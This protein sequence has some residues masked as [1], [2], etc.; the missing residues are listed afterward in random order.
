M[1]RR[2]FSSSQLPHLEQSIRKVVSIALRKQES[3]F[4]HFYPCMHACMFWTYSYVLSSFSQRRSTLRCHIQVTSLYHTPYIIR[5][6]FYLLY[7]FLNSLLTYLIFY[8]ICTVFSFRRIFF[9]RRSREEI[10]AISVQGYSLRDVFKVHFSPLL[11]YCHSILL[12]FSMLYLLYAVLSPSVC[13]TRNRRRYVKFFFRSGNEKEPKFL[14]YNLWD[15]GGRKFCI[16]FLFFLQ[17]FLFIYTCLQFQ[18]YNVYLVY[19]HAVLTQYISY[20]VYEMILSVI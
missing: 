16:I 3:F 17:T 20:G 12:K 1:L 19:T 14:S 18:M 6:Y 8:Q 4:S 5:R 10:S 9:L 7:I 13:P 2:H 15:C 11:K